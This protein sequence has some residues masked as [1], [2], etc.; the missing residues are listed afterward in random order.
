MQFVNARAMKHPVYSMH[1]YLKNQEK[2]ALK[3]TEKI[4]PIFNFAPLAGSATRI[5]AQAIVPP[6][7]MPY[8]I[9]P[10]QYVPDKSPAKRTRKP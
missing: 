5:K 6:E 3:T 10:L 9:S 4:N 2:T 7:N 8:N 1:L